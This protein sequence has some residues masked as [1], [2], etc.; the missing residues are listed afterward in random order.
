MP[1]RG[2]ATLRKNIFTRFCW[3]MELC[4]LLTA[5]SFSRSFYVNKKVLDIFKA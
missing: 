3:F 2:K 5:K 4:S 1:Q